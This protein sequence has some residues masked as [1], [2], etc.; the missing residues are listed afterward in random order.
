MRFLPCGRNNRLVISSKAYSPACPC[1]GSK[2]DE[3]GVEATCLQSDIHIEPYS[4]P[5]A[6]CMALAQAGVRNAQ[7]A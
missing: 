6:A 5:N 1:W 2:V 4:R 3:A 7:W